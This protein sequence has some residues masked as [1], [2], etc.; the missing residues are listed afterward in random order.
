V[1]NTNFDSEEDEYQVGVYPNP[2]RLNAAWDGTTPFNRRIMFYNLPERAEIR[3]YTL[4][5]ETVAT[6]DHDAQ[7][8]TGD[9]R[10][11]R[12][13]SAPNRIMSGGEHAWDLL[14]SANQNLATGLYLYTVYDKDSGKVQQGRFVVIK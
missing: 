8:Y 12:D 1:V 10:W 3:V 13:F 7:T 11:F 14:T 6:L 9:T 2:Y 4:A 5:G